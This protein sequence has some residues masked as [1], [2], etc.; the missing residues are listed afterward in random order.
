MVRE[1]SASPPTRARKFAADS[2]FTTNFT[3]TTNIIVVVDDAFSLKH[4]ELRE[5]PRALDRIEQLQELKSIARQRGAIAPRKNI[6]DVGCG[7]GRETLRLAA[8]GPPRGITAGVDK[9]AGF[10]QDA[11]KRAAAAGL[12]TDLRVAYATALPFDDSTF[13]CGR[14]ER[15]LVYLEDVASAI[16][17]MRR[18]AKPRGGIAMVEPEFSTTTV[19]SP[20]RPLVRRVMAHEVDT[21]VVQSWLPGQLRGMHADHGFTEIELASRVLVFQH[22]LGAAY[23]HSVVERLPRPA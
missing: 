14:A 5:C 20:N 23:F 7:F 12:K 21:A 1:S 17:E 13:D 2:D 8:I 9:S 10:I 19:N 6:P 18:V 4:C 3:L 22:G 16:S 15:L 11:R